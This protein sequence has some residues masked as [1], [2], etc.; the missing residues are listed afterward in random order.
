MSSDNN[1]A[2]AA[3]FFAAA[4]KR[5]SETKNFTI[6]LQLYALFF[7]NLAL[8]Y[9]RCVSKRS[10]LVQKNPFF[11]PV[12]SPIKATLRHS[13]EKLPR[14]YL[15]LHNPP[16]SVIFPATCNG[17]A[18]ILFSPR[19]VVDKG[20]YTVFKDI[21][22][23]AAQPCAAFFVTLMCRIILSNTNPPFNSPL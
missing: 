11:L 18:K 15:K 7:Y 3:I 2:A 1:I 5:R 19:K 22:K 17:A 23:N 16:C 13:G 20:G 14:R 10:P 8:Y 21:H 12:R 9:N 4:A 6:F